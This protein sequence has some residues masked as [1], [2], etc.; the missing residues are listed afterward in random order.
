M[1][2]SS[3]DMAS[4]VTARF[5]LSASI[6][7]EGEVSAGGG[8]GRWTG[9]VWARE[10]DGLAVGLFKENGVEE[11]VNMGV[12]KEGG[13]VGWRTVEA[14]GA[15]EWEGFEFEGFSGLKLLSWPLVRSCSE[16][17]RAR[18]LL[19]EGLMPLRPTRRGANCKGGCNLGCGSC[20]EACSAVISASPSSSCWNDWCSREDRRPLAAVPGRLLFPLSPDST[21]PLLP[22]TLDGLPDADVPPTD[23]APNDPCCPSRNASRLAAN[24]LLVL[25][26]TVFSIRSQAKPT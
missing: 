4:G 1:D 12:V 6:L 10:G 11:E 2:E 9:E 8:L 18:G 15:A 19:G 16:E 13:G 23:D 22:L 3:R 26:L 17:T 14:G 5:L 21:I 25:L 20:S 24:R 7:A